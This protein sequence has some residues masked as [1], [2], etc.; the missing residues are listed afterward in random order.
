MLSLL[1]INVY[2]DNFRLKSFLFAYNL[3]ESLVV[4]FFIY[5][6]LQNSVPKCVLTLVLLV[7]VYFVN[8]LN[9][10]L[11]WM[12]CYGEKNPQVKDLFN[13]W[14]FKQQLTSQTQNS[15]DKESHFDR[16]KLFA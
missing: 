1:R 11:L 9:E 8:I 3:A 12:Y 7:I 10:Y 2:I 15:S 14:I 5:E 13:K 16:E 6:S 4:L